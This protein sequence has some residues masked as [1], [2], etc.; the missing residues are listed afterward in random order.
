MANICVSEVLPMAERAVAGTEGASFF[1]SSN[2]T[3][4]TAH[5]FQH[6]QK[7]RFGA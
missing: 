5:R 2:S 1:G 4:Q 7:L 3:A 6:L